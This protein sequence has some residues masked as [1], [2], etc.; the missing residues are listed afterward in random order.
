MKDPV[1]GMEVREERRTPNT[2]KTKSIDF[3]V[4]HVD[5]PLSR[6]LNNL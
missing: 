2:I 5:G 3:V 6:I 4:L 1:C